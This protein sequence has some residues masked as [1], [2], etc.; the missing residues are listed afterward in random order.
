MKALTIISAIFAFCLT[1][2]VQ[3]QEY[4]AIVPDYV[5]TP[6]VIDTESIGTLEFFDGMPSP[7]TVSKVYDF[8]D[9]GRGV[10]AFLNGIP[11]TSIYAALRG[12]EEAGMRPN[13]IGIFEQLMDAKSLWLTPNSTTVY[14]VSHVDLSNG[15][16]VA[17]IPP[18]VLGLLDDAFF[19]YVTDFGAAGPDKGE[20]GKY[21]ILP[22][23][24][25]GEVPEGYFV[26][27]SKTYHNWY[28]VR[29]FVRNGDLKAAA[30]G[31]KAGTRL[32]RLS[33]A[34]NPPVQVFHN[35]SGVQ[36]NTI[37]ANTFEFYE[38][39]N[40][41]IQREPADA[42][43]PELVGIFAAIGIKK[44]EP[45]EPDAR[46][47]RILTEAAA[48]G[49]ATARAITYSPRSDRV[50]FWEDRQWNSPFAG[51]SHEF[52]ND[53]ERVLDDRVYFHY[54][55]TGITPAMVNSAVGQGSAYAHVAKDSN[56]EYLD[57]GKNYKI[58]L[59]G[60]VP[61]KDFWSFMVY[62][63]Q[64]R[65]MLETDQ[66]RAGL[67]SLSESLV[68][69]DDGS[70]SVW[71]GPSPPE[72]GEGNWVQTVPGKSFSSL[73]RLYGPL[74]PWFDKTWRPGDFELIE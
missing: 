36:Y 27:Q 50:Y 46:M 44:G 39:L 67:D 47:R 41:V 74:E 61:A 70:Y 24:Y 15:P 25:E 55:A 72:A 30:D 52:M 34:N 17:E 6:D 7:E 66:R 63:G 10:D 33:Q 56:G 3:A 48:I 26:A 1:A 13:E 31:V 18:G 43:D 2:A 32:Y 62:S 8:I 16:I 21:L 22:P 20:G 51:G 29:A 59:P 42:F 53:G 28:L 40:E 45:F 64:H 57:G 60:P 65:S 14:V 68:A 69:N 38:E 11:A 19:R 58:D 23:G 9:L 4:K 71:F 12:C 49:N 35:L 73:F 5:L 37:H 54:L